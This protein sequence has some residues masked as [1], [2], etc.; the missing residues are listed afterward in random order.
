MKKRLL[1]LS[2]ICGATF[3]MQAQQ[4][5]C[6]AHTHQKTLE[7]ANPSL[8][9]KRQAIEA[10]TADYVANPQ[11]HTRAVVNIPVVVHVL[12]NTA[13]QNISDAQIAS[14]IT[15]LNADFRKLNAD[16]SLVPAAFAG[17]AADCE[18]QFCMAQRDPSGNATTGIIR[19]STTKTVFDATLDDAK[20]ATSGSAA[21]PTG[22]YLNLWVVPSIKDGPMTGIL[23]YAQFPGGP[24][25]TDGVV[26]AYQYFG[27]TGTAVAPF[28]KGRTA[29][30]E[31]G[32]WFNC[33]HIWGDDDNGNGT[34][35][36]S[37]ECSGSDLVGDTPNQCE[38]QYGCPTFPTTDGCSASSPGVMFMNY[39]DYT[40]DACMYMFTLGQKARMQALFAAGGSRASLATSLGCQAPTGGTTC[41][42]ATALT[43]SAITTTGATLSW[44]AAANATSYTVGYKL[45]SATTFTNISAT[46]TSA[47]LSGLTASS[48]YNWQVTANCASGSSAA[49]AGANFTTLA[50][51]GGGCTDNYEA[52]ETRTAGK[53]I[54]PGTIISAKIGTATDKDWFKFSN[55][56][57]AKNI[58]VDLTNLPADYDLKLYRG[59]TLVGTSQLGGTANEQLKY[60][61]GTITTYYANVYGYGGVFN[62]TSCYNLLA[63]LSA[64]AWRTNGG[65]EI[66]TIEENINLEKI[67]GN[68]DVSI[69]PNP[70]N[71]NLNLDILNL[72]NSNMANITVIDVM[73]KVVSNTVL[74]VINGINSTSLNLN[75]P[76]GVYQIMV[77][78]DEDVQI[79]RVMIQK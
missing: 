62:A 69:Y 46:G 7:L 28:N 34:C 25:S 75:V 17:V 58:K 1:L 65:A 19:K 16:A 8:I 35:T 39:M 59:A 6:N 64:T 67:Q 73:G 45:A 56:S 71:G 40:D 24:A 23:G 41:G 53:A 66:P 33:A 43:S 61:N 3:S 51:T 29:T 36:A 52:N 37:G 60:N 9:L 74:N 10:H 30:H 79:K 54:T 78:T 76:N 18:F 31:V 55:T 12:Y 32:H 2:I 57:A 21:W 63:S 44:A 68:L 11:K 4:R 15:V 14:Q 20:S 50:N 42:S 47:T 26:I 77:R 22:S 27:T 49:V 48:T 13:T 38:R 72:S 70:S 5:N